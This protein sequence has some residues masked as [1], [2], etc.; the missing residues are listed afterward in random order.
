MKWKFDVSTDFNLAECKAYLAIWAGSAANSVRSFVTASITNLRMRG[1]RVIE[2][3]EASFTRTSAIT[4]VCTGSS[5]WNSFRG[6]KHQGVPGVEDGA[7]S[8][9]PRY[10]VIC[11]THAIDLHREFNGNIFLAEVS[12]HA[13]HSPAPSAMAHHNDSRSVFQFCG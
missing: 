12:S 7:G 2:R 6:H 10:G 11:E 13:Q 5:R 8:Y 9:V 1:S 3:C 4:F